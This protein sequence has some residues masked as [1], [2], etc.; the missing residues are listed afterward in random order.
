M[1]IQNKFQQRVD[2]YKTQHFTLCNAF[3]EIK[4]AQ[5]VRVGAGGWRVLMT[6]NTGATW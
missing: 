5:K 3:V 1:E 6:P 4:T 2:K